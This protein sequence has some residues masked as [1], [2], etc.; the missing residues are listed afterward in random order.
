M[1]SFDLT[2]WIAAR[3]AHIAFACAVNDVPNE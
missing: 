3:D 1:K 2:A